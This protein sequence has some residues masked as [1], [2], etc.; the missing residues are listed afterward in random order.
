LRGIVYTH[1]VERLLR[2]AFTSRRDLRIYTCL[3]SRELSIS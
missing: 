1:S 3:P 2:K